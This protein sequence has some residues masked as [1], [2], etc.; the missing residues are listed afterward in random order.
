MTKEEMLDNVRAY[1]ENCLE[2]G[3]EPDLD[4]LLEMTG[5]I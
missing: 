4:D 1:L 5:A 3:D 2:Y